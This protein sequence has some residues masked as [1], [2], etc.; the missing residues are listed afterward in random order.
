VTEV[1][2]GNPT[3]VHVNLARLQRFKRFFLAGQGVVNPNIHIL[4][5]LKSLIRELENPLKPLNSLNS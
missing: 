5:P 3:D 2:C 1:I 4:K